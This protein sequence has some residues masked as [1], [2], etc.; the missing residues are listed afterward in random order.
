MVRI[1][2]KL[3]KYENGGR[4]V[5]IELEPKIC[6][7]CRNRYYIFTMCVDCTDYDLWEP[8]K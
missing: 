8:E 2:G 5:P 7:E 6:K 1:E 3:V 4:D